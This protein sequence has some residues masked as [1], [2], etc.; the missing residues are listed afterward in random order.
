[1]RSEVEVVRVLKWPDEDLKETGNDSPSGD[2]YL[3][4]SYIKIYVAI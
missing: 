2:V 3:Q 4:E 1:M